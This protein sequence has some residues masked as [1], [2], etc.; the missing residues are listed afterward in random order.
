M[1]RKTE[2]LT[3]VVETSAVPVSL[4][5]STPAHC[6]YFGEVVADG[7]LHTSVYIRKE[8]IRRWVLTYIRMAFTTDHFPDLAGALLHLNQD[9]GIRDVKTQNHAIAILLKQKGAISNSRSAAMELGRLAVAE[10]KKFDRRFRARIPNLSGCLIGDQPLKVDFNRLFDDLRAFVASVGSTDACDVNEFL[11]FE[12]NGVGARLLDVPEVQGTKSGKQLA[13]LRNQKKRISCRE[14]AKIGDAVIALEQ[15]EEHSLVHIDKD[16]EILCMATGRPHT[17]I[18]SERA[19]E[20]LR[21][22]AP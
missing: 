6:R 14:C 15:P 20:K 3:Y 9:F 21:Q 7:D 2:N 13:T 11:G 17:P 16:F 12:S 22:E 8:F 1:T 4:F 10:L 19:I 18:L 5:E